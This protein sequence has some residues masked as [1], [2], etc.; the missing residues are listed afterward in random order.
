MSQ[1]ISG[2]AFSEDR[3]VFVNG[4]KLE[5]NFADIDST[6]SGK[7]VHSFIFAPVYGIGNRKNGVIQLY[8]KKEGSVNKGDAKALW[9][10]QHTLG[11][12]LDSAMELN[13]ALDFML[14]AKVTMASIIKRTSL[15]TADTV[16][17]PV[18]LL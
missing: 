13:E 16:V 11:R 10:M 12:V 5:K 14:T 3:V 8:N 7:T 9:L 1:G 18:S 6:E 2:T 4:D 17:V 15:H